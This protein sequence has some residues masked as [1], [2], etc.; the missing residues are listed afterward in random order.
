MPLGNVRIGQNCFVDDNVVIGYP[1]RQALLEMTKRGNVPAELVALDTHTRGELVSESNCCVRYG[2]IISI[3][4]HIGKGVYCDVRTHIGTRCRIG[5]DTQLLYGA[6]IYND[7]SI[8]DKCRVGGFCCDRSV[9]EDNVSMFGDLVHSYRR[10]VG[11]LIEPSPIIRQGATIGWKAVI[12]GGIEI[13]T[14]TYVAAGAIVA[15]DIPAD[16]VVIGAA[17]HVV[18]RAE[19]KGE[20]SKVNDQTTW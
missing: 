8:G 18:D 13:G 7:V 14:Y 5:R 17:G 15:K 20:L 10:P 12:I 2:S 6:K 1:G 16:S 4:T 19:W 9:I 11:G 3:E